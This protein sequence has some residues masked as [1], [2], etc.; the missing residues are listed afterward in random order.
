MLRFTASNYIFFIQSTPVKL[1]KAEVLERTVDYVKRT[2]DGQMGMLYYCT[3]N[4]SNNKIT[5]HRAIFQR[6]RQ[7]SYVNKQTKSVNNWKTWKIAM[8]LTWY[9][10]FQR[11]GGLNQILRRQAS[12]FYYG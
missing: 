2:K 12:R 4:K 6:E 10:H 8:A 7:N 9:R 5:E 1:E 11:N 3:E